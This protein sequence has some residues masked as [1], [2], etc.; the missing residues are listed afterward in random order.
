MLN[1]YAKAALYSPKVTTTH[2]CLPSSQLSQSIEL[3][4]GHINQFNKI[5]NWHQLVGASLHP[6][7]IQVLS[8]P[9]QMEMMIRQPFPFKVWGLVHI[10]NTIRVKHLPQATGN[11][12]INTQFGELFRHRRGVVFEVVTDAFQNEQKCLSATSYYLARINEQTLNQ[13][14]PDMPLFSETSILA[15]SAD[16]AYQRIAELAFSVDAGRAYAKVSGD[17]NPIHL[18]PITANIF[19]FK[20]AIVHGMYSKALIFSSL[21]K[22]DRTR[23]SRGQFTFNTVFKSPISLPNT[24]KLEWDGSTAFRLVSD[25]PQKLRQH[26]LGELNTES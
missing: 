16:E 2:F 26:V 6:N 8:L 18:W 22:L 13:K 12:T 19:G 24:T 15:G 1:L 9:M 23:F 17:Y 21:H 10:A 11:L 14:A 25:G 5:V 7:Y 3:D 4:I 20:R